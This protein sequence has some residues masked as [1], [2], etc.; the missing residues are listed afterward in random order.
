MLYDV[1]ANVVDFLHWVLIV[2]WVGGWFVSPYL[3]PEFR[4]VHSYLSVV[5]IPFQ[6]LFNMSC[7]MVVLSAHLRH[8]AHPEKDIQGFLRPFIVRFLQDVCGFTVSDICVTIVI[9]MG[10]VAAAWTLL[11]INNQPQG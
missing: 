4:R 2:V 10:A 7:P 11:V 6:L 9:L 5:I 8:L 1:L 3:H